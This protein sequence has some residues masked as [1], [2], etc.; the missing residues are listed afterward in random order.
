MFIVPFCSL[1]KYKFAK[2]TTL[3]TF[4]DIIHNLMPHVLITPQQMNGIKRIMM[5][6]SIDIEIPK[7]CVEGRDYRFIDPKTRKR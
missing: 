3:S 1:D 4:L 5:N 7:D 2:K 6:I